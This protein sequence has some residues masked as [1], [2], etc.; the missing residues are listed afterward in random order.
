MTLSVD[1]SSTLTQSITLRE[2]ANVPQD[3]E[4]PGQEETASGSDDFNDDG[5]G[6]NGDEA[7]DAAE[8]PV[9]ATLASSTGSGGVPNLPGASSR[10]LS[11]KLSI[12]EIAQ[13]ASTKRYQPPAFLRWMEVP[14]RVKNVQTGVYVEE[15]T[16]HA[17][18][19]AARGPINQSGS[20][21]GSAMIR[22]AAMQAGGAN[23]VVYGMR[24]SS[25]LSISSLI[26][27]IAA[28][29]TMPCLGAI[30][31]HTDHRKTMGLVSALVC[32]VSVIFQ[33]MLGPD[34]WFAMFILEII[35]GYFLI[36]HQVC[37]MAY[38]PD[39]TH[40]VEEIGHYTSRFMM[41]QYF[42]QG[43]FTSI[44]ISVSFTKPLSNLQTARMAAGLSGGLGLIMLGYAWIFLFRKRPKLREVPPGSNLWTSGFKQL[45]KTAKV[46]FRE[47][48]ALK[49][50]MIALL[51]SPEAGA[52]VV[53]AIAVTF[54]TVFVGMDVREI[55]V[56]SIIMQLGNIPGA[57]I[58]KKMCKLINPL[59]SFRCAEI[60]FAL[61]NGLIV[62]TVT[63]A[64]QKDKNLVY[65]FGGMVGVSFGWMFPSQRTLAVALI[66]KGQETEIMG[67][68]S[69]FGQIVGW[70]PVFV[71]T[72]MNEAGVSMRWGLSIVSF[73]LLTSCFFT[74][75]CGKF[76]D[77]VAL[78]AHTSDNYLQE[79]SRKSGVQGSYIDEETEMAPQDQKKEK[80]EGAMGN[81]MSTE[82]SA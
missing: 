53:L 36:M 22:L 8:P 13:E 61:I 28:G 26:V 5:L 71:F 81:T 19:Y 33:V 39:L 66:P 44:I 74:L 59:N 78:V 75:F 49:W 72:A 64:T 48:R 77:A 23:E 55:A 41:N 60:A 17:M 20:F 9:G 65:I 21:V 29:V 70:L 11:R 14:F 52:G 10:K 67:L 2:N 80:E 34:T 47:Y 56:V 3:P 15:A 69:F 12:S 68:I 57:H 38:L 58:S 32:V 7:A 43:I 35:G 25:V 62:L 1:K 24:A 4:Q 30:V 54:L 18:D 63:G 79:F 6:G 37:T 16:G 82:I 42:Y 27:G 31:D 46:V 40:D 73:F 45:H 76:E 50:F 51:F